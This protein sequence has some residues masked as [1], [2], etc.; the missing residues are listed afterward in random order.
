MRPVREDSPTAE[1]IARFD[2]LKNGDLLDGFPEAFLRRM[3]I[4]GHCADGRRLCGEN[5]LK[6][7]YAKR[8]MA[9]F[10]GAGV[11]Y[12]SGIPLWREV[13]ERAVQQTFPNGSSSA[14]EIVSS[15]AAARVSITA[16]LDICDR[17]L[18]SHPSDR[19]FDQ[20]LYDSL[21]GKPDFEALREHLRRS[22][23]PAAIGEFQK[24]KTLCAL[25]DMLLAGSPNRNIHAVLT[26]NA[27]NLLQL[28]TR[29]V[30][31][32]HR[33]V[34]SIQGPA[35]TPL[36]GTIPVFH[37]HGYLDARK[38]ADD[39]ETG[40]YA[41]GLV[42]KESEY[43]QTF[44]DPASFANYTPLSILQ[45]NNAMIVGTA[46]DDIDI[47]RWLYQSASERRSHRRA[48]LQ[49][50][51]SS[52]YDAADQEAELDTIRHF[53][54]RSE[55]EIPEPREQIK[56]HLDHSVREL[57]TEI[58]WCPDFDSLASSLRNLPQGNS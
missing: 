53:W 49:V 35:D 46:L 32:G 55:T 6:A 43:F 44:S 8:G 37:L 14:Q 33:L 1:Q 54:L 17:M 31:G 36:P 28:Y 24:N 18:G 21:Y 50:L 5:R 52:H 34:S 30:A 29:A 42:F 23:W 4:Q 20:I 16:Q 51:Y 57:G 22:D 9:V 40:E 12:G 3:E 26:T 58:I 48:E 19:T 47:R 15:L 2:S 10:A 13:V 39:V 7:I 41:Y 45:R 25:G 56:S 38:N 11:S 27:D